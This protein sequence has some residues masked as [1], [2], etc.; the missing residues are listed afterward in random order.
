MREGVAVAVGVV[1]GAGAVLG[2]GAVFCSDFIHGQDMSL[3][4]LLTLTTQT[5]HL[6][7]GDRGCRAESFMDTRQKADQNLISF[8][9]M[10]N[11]QVR[12]AHN[13]WLASLLVLK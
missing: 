3:L 10:S 13:I 9:W 12:S 4:M 6:P 8:L 5:D 11:A 2:V 1:A 7:E